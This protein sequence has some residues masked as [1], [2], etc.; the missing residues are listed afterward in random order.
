MFEVLYLIADCKTGKFLND[1]I[2]GELDFHP[3]SRLLLVK[4]SNNRPELLVWSDS[5]WIKIPDPVQKRNEAI[6]NTLYGEKADL[7][8]QNLPNP[9]HLD[10]LRFEGL[11]KTPA[12]D[13][14]FRELGTDST[15]S[16]ICHRPR[17]KSPECDVE[18]Q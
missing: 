9:K 4:N 18:V 10:R 12:L 13:A 15:I 6:Q 5:Q 11:K 14:L 17:Q 3:D 7:L 8:I 2:K 16:G 1:S